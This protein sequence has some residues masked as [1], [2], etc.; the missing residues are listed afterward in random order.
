MVTKSFLKSRQAGSL[1]TCTD[2]TVYM[3]VPYTGRT[4]YRHG[5]IARS[6]P[7]CRT[8]TLYFYGA[9]LIVIWTCGIVQVCVAMAPPYKRARAQNAP[10]NVRL[11]NLVLWIGRM[12]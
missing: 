4:I 11:L 5:M 9:L 10:G 12:Y 2:D 8:I 7:L 6:Q 3:P 1:H